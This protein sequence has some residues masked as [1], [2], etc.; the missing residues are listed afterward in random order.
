M[1]RIVVVY[2]SRDGHTRGIAREIARACD[3]ELHEIVEPT[4]RAGPFGYLRSAL[5]ALLGMAPTLK[6]SKHV[7]Q[8]DDV[9]VVGT[10][11]WFWNIA[12]PVR[13]YLLAHHAEI[14]RVAFF[15]C[16]GGSGS[17]KVLHDLRVLCHRRPLATLALTE[18]QC[19][20]GAHQVELARFVRALR[21]QRTDLA[22]I[23]AD[24]GDRGDSGAR[25]D[26]R[27]GPR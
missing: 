20:R 8:P 22:P 27:R 3:G 10:P 17:G 15:C 7:L 24:R 21:R 11:V 2:C 26:A 14:H 19:T 23:A 4:R 9:V 25:L 1:S 18:Q 13:S 12:S 6:P 16:F 5:E